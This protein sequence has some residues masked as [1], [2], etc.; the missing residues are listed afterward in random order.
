MGSEQSH[1]ASHS[2]QPQGQGASNQ[3]VPAAEGSKQYCEDTV[4][5]MRDQSKE[6]SSSPEP[7]PVG[8]AL[9]V[10]SLES[11]S[12]EDKL[13]SF[14]TNPEEALAESDKADKLMMNMMTRMR[15]RLKSHSKSKERVLEPKPQDSA[16]FSRNKFAHTKFANATEII[17]S[18]ML[19]STGSSEFD[20]TEIIQP[21][22]FHKRLSL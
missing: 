22:S 18:P 16:R 3:A 17:Q 12:N 21:A 15:N 4:S 13:P 8:S 5:K 19:D 6:S 14:A 2:D 10:P 7:T 1:D 11:I 9:I 20:D